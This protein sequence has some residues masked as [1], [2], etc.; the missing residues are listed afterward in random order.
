M[1]I[2]LTNSLCKKCP[3]SAFKECHYKR[4]FYKKV[5]KTDNNFKLVHKCIHYWK[6]FKQGQI[7][8]ID[9]HHQVR[10]QDNKWE[11]VKAYSDV[12]GIIKGT[13]GNKYVIELFEAFLLLRKNKIQSQQ[14]QVRLYIECARAAKDI[15]PFLLSKHSVKNTQNI[16]I[17]FLLKDHQQN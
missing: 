12:P 1:K 17:K 10:V 3:Y 9:L 2:Y 15:R 13:R 11:Y 16:P 4:S 6:I 5:P 7:V 14:G 8:L